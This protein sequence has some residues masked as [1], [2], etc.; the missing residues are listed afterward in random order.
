[1]TTAVT[2]VLASCQRFLLGRRSFAHPGQPAQAPSSHWEFDPA[3]RGAGLAASALRVSRRAQNTRDASRHAP[4][5][6]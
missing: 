6:G 4:Q 1:M 5:W 3:S 2:T